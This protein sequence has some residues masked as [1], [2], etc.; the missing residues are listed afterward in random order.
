MAALFGHED[1]F[2]VDVVSHRLEKCAGSVED[3]YDSRTAN[4]HQ[5]FFQIETNILSVRKSDY[6]CSVPKNR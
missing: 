4:Q 1:Q 2:L 3:S 6:Y 5:V